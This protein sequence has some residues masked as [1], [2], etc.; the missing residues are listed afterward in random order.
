MKKRPIVALL[1]VTALALSLVAAP[2][3]AATP[4]AQAGVITAPTKVA[5]FTAPVTPPD[6]TW[7]VISNFGDWIT[8]DGDV[9]ASIEYSETSPDTLQFSVSA[10]MLNGDYVGEFDW[11]QD[12][13]MNGSNYTGLVITLSADYVSTLPNGDYTFTLVTDDGNVP[14]TLH[15]GPTTNPTKGSVKFKTD[16]LSVKVGASAELGYDVVAPDGATLTDVTLKSSDPTVASVDGESE[17]AGVVGKKA[18]T[19]TITITAT[20]TNGTTAT[21]TVTVTVTDGSGGST[22]GGS[23]GSTKPASVKS[24][25]VGSNTHTHGSNTSLLHSTDKDFNLFKSVQVDGKTITEGKDYTAKA[26]STDITL[27]PGY[28]NSL[29][30]GSHDLTVLFSDGSR[31]GATFKIVAAKSTAAALTLPKTGDSSSLGAAFA[32]ILVAAVVGTAVTAIRRG[33]SGSAA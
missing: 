30:V 12:D 5:P 21:D 4:V 17:V 6:P 8:G 27:L 32:A 31:F 15:V 10:L 19:A 26:G 7:S 24:G 2:A 25:F 9:T 23:G 16:K 14:L 33:R 20:F 22:G 11:G 28:L 18:G 29:S 13:L 3:F 1:M